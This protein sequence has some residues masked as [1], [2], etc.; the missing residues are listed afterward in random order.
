MLVYQRVRLGMAKSYPIPD[1]RGKVC[2]H[3]ELFEPRCAAARLWHR[4]GSVAM[5]IRRFSEG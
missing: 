1:V 3:P 4:M 5:V 2:N